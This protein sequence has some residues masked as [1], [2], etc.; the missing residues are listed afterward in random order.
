MTAV[1]IRCQR[2]GMEFDAPETLVSPMDELGG[3]FL[4]SAAYAEYLCLECKEE[5]GMS[6][7]IGFLK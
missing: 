6:N 7:M 2:C 1:L 5:L 3:I 4:G